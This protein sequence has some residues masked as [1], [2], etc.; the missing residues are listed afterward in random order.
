MTHVPGF[1]QNQLVLPPPAKGRLSE[2]EDHGRA[3]CQP[4]ELNAASNVAA[5][6]E[7]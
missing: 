3:R 4:R 1:M 6:V 2:R 7:E 5:S